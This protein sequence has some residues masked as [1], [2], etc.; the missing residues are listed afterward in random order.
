MS[1]YELKKEL[2]IAQQNVLKFNQILNLTKKTYS[3]L[4]H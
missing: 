2:K 4:S 1:L 3:N